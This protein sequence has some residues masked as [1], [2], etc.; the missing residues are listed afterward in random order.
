MPSPRSSATR[1]I[2]ALLLCSL[3]LIAAACEPPPPPPTAD[4]L[5]GHRNGTGCPAGQL[6]DICSRSA[7]AARSDTA[8]RAVKFALSQI[9][10][11]YSSAGRFGPHAYDCSGLVWQSYASSGVDIGANLS[12]TIVEAGGPR[13][14]V[15]LTQVR[16]GDVLWYPGHVA[17]ALADGRIVEAAKPG[18]SVRVVSSAHRGF[19]RAVA[20]QG[21]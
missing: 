9:G 5:T 11:P 12:S 8:A 2:T 21:P 4:P 17:I 1:R 13:W 14:S 3:A 18:T 15:P 6:H 16:P 7:G 10:V 19:T 20:I